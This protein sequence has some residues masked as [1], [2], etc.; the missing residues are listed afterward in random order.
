MRARG[1]RGYNLAHTSLVLYYYWDKTWRE[2]ASYFVTNPREVCAPERGTGAPWGMRPRR[3]AQARVCPSAK[4]SRYRVASPRA[5]RTVRR[6]RGP[7]CRG[8]PTREVRT[9][10]ASLQCAYVRLRCR[11]PTPRGPCS[12][13]RRTLLR[14]T[15]AHLAAV[16]AS[17][18]ADFATFVHPNARSIIQDKRHEQRSTTLAAAVVLM[19]HGQSRFNQTRFKLRD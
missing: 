19:N 11:I 5:R 3:C 6:R 8:D 16:C 10:S 13:L 14:R 4:A 18:E 9:G 7:T 1:A 15:R 12:G 2:F 17:S